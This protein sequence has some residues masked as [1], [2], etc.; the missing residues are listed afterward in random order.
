MMWSSKSIYGKNKSSKPDLEEKLKGSQK[1]YKEQ[2]M[3]DGSEYR[4]ELKEKAKDINEKA[5]KRI[6]KSAK[7]TKKST[8]RVGKGFEKKANKKRKKLAKKFFG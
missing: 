4:Q 8:S 2:K 5:R 7:R 6:K 1:A 3:K